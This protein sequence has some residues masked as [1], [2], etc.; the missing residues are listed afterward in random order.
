MILVVDVGNT[1]TV[2]GLYKNDALV[3]HWRLS[4]K[5]DRTSDEVWILLRAWCNDV[6]VN[7]KHIKGIVICSVVP[8]LT[9]VFVVLSNQYLNLQPLIITSETDSGLIILY[10]SPRMV[11]ADRICNAVAAY[12]EF[13]GPVIVVDFGTAT[14]F[15]V[16]SKKGEYIGGVIALGLMGA[17]QELHRVA[18][19]LPKVDL[20]F[21][22]KIVGT[23]TETSMQSGIMWGTIAMI[24][25]MIDKIINELQWKSCHAIATGG[26]ASVVAEKSKNIYKVKHNLTLDG[27]YII[28]Q[29][30]YGK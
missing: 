16:V 7:I 4:S 11:G 29:R 19:K 18:A 26:I 21:P 10:D 14:T 12:D 2:F 3:H 9:S 23:T 20:L 15:D 25:G 28:Y 5:A 27:L 17:S 22:D 24:D 30:N 8:S 1:E 13:G 6:N